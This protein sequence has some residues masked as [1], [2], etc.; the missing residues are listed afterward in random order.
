[1]PVSFRNLAW[2]RNVKLGKEY[3][4]FGQKLYEALTDSQSAHNQ[5]EGQTN[6][7]LSGQSQPPPALSAV[8]VSGGNG[9]FHVSLD[10]N[11]DFYR[12]VRY[13]VEY[14]TD[15]HF[16]NPFPLP[17][18]EARE[19]RGNLGQQKLYF[20][21][22]ASYG[23]SGPNTQW[24][25][26]GGATPQL[27]DGTGTTEPPLPAQSQGSGTGYPG[28]GLQGSGQTQFRSRSGQPPTRVTG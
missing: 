16:S 7:N 5:L 11:A 19:W 23:I 17:M 2:L 28:Q 18:H 15:P 12:G 22:S 3:P 21:A 27:V 24:T 9:L 20:R 8:R 1:M 4:N 25:Y 10:H 26:F 14:A 6:G 13:H